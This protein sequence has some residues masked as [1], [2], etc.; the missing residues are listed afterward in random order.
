[1]AGANQN[2]WIIGGFSLTL[3]LMGLVSFASYKNITAIRENSDKVQTTYE[4]INNLSDFHA[5]MT[6]AESGRRGYVASGDIAELERY[7]KAVREI[8]AELNL[9]QKQLQYAAPSQQQQLAALQRLVNQRLAL[10]KQSIDLY[11]RNSL[12]SVTQKAITVESIKLREKILVILAQM[13]ADEEQLLQSW[14]TRSRSHI[15]S[16]VL[17]SFVGTILSFVVID[18]IFL[19]LYYQWKQEQEMSRI[20]QELKQEKEIIELKN[21]LFSMISH[22]FRTPLSVIL[23]SSQL[24]E[25]SLTKEV[26]PKLFK[27]IYRIQSS[28]KLMNQFL[29]DLLTLSRAESGNLE[30]N[31]VSVDLEA[32]CLNLV[33]NMQLIATEKHQ[34]KMSSEVVCQR[35]YLDEKLLYSI[36]SNV[37]LNAIKYSPEGGSI[38]FI[39]KCEAE[40]TVFQIKDQGIGILVDDLPKIYQPFYRGQNVEQIVGTGLGLAVVQKCLELYHGTIEVESNVYKGTQFTITIPHLPRG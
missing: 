26:E 7:R 38:D 31:L 14:L 8:Q 13:K 34:I 29:T 2:K 10:L 22:E 28:V 33:E 36:L 27:N 16:R 19:I 23:S 4:I 18:G 32:F 9:L 3:L 11:Q 30:F 39:L 20:Q 24:L 37:L 6:V 35:I 40:K 5:S 17:L 15:Q 21:K 25:N 12:D 1:M